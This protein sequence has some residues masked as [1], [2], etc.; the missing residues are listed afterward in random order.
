[1][2]YVLSGR[3]G[4]VAG[5]TWQVGDGTWTLGSG[6]SAAV[7]LPP[8]AGAQPLHARLDIR[9]DQLVLTPEAGLRVAV[10]GQAVQGPVQLRAGDVLTLGGA[11]LQVSPVAA[12][13]RPARA[14]NEPIGVALPPPDPPKWRILAAIFA[15]ALTVAA[16]VAVFRFVPERRANPVELIPTDVREQVRAGTV[17]IRLSVPGGESEGSG[18][19]SREG[20]VLT[21]AHVVAGGK[22]ATVVFDPGLPT[23]RKM[24]AKVVRAG[25]PGEVDDIALLSVATGQVRPLPLAEPAKLLEGIAVAAFGFP[26]GSTVSTSSLG[27][28][29]SIRTGR[30]TALRRDDAGRLQWVESDVLA[31]VGNSGGP[32]VTFDG[33]VVGLATM[34][35][36]PNL[37]TARIVPADVLARFAPG[38][39]TRG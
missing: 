14:A 29:I 10:N 39:V 6:P 22:T 27:P 16:V 12:P 4:V 8:Q 15:V 3:V 38:A 33:K 37:R 30:I 26:L 25:H 23:M 19:V 11:S 24:P 5:K 32:V 9:G 34:L 7:R 2:A 13:A 20:Y 21:N 1:M 36:G 18:F 35:V 28:Q 17:W 31:E